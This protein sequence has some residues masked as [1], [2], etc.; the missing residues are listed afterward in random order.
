MQ[1]IESAIEIGTW[2]N[3]RKRTAVEQVNKVRPT[4]SSM[5]LVRADRYIESN[6]RQ[7]P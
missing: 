1:K 2:L 7:T 5:S 4:T 6:S 3:D